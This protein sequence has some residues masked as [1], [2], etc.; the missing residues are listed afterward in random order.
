VATNFGPT[1]G[2]GGLALAGSAWIDSSPRF[3]L[4]IP[5]VQGVGVIDMLPVEVWGAGYGVHITG[6][7]PYPPNLTM[8]AET[9]YV[10]EGYFDA[11]GIQLKRGR[12]LSPLLD[13]S[14]NLAGTMVVNEAFEHKF[15]S[16]GGDPVGAHI[17]DAPKPESKSGIVGVVTNVRQ[18]CVSRRWRRWTGSWMRSFRRTGCKI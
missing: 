8:G 12:M 5:G 14:E 10:S 7:P 4:H 18:P 3:F 11:M 15:F 17:D 9:R 16:M 1:C 6:R 2:A 13:K